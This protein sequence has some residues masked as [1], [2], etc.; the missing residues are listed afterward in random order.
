MGILN[1][2]YRYKFCRVAER[3]EHAAEIRR[4]ILHDKRER[5]IFL[6]SRGGKREIAERQKRD[7]RHIVGDKHRADER[8]ANERDNACARVFEFLHDGTRGDIEKSDSF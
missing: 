6:L 7:E 4:D 3:S 5:H 8:N 1:F 2:P